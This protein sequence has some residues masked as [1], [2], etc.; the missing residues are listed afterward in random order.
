SGPQVKCRNTNPAVLG[1]DVTLTCEF[2]SHLD[3]LQVTWQRKRGENTQNMA[4]YS[5]MYNIADLFE[6][7]VSIINASSRNSTIKISKLEKGDEGCYLCLFNAYPNGA[8]TGEVC[9][10]VLGKSNNK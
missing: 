6:S 3:V 5:E 8:F 2:Q 4:T 7:H 1:E 9:L 10:T